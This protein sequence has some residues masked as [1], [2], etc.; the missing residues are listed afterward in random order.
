EAMSRANDAEIDRVE[1]QGPSFSPYFYF[2]DEDKEHAVWFLDAVT[3]LNQLREVRSQKA[4]GLA[5]YRL[6]TED[7]AIWDALS[8]PQ[9]F[10]FDTRTRQSLEMIKSTD[11]IADVGEGEIV[12]VD[13]DRKDGMRKLAVDTDGYLTAKYVQFAQ[14]PTLYHQG[15]GGEHQVAITFD[16]GPDPRWTPKILDILKAANAKATFFLVG[17][18]AERYPGLVRR[19]VNEG[20]EIG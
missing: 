5:L 11:T 1:V 8:A 6:G 10:K 4:G 14:F 9:D 17:V 16:D 13:E 19:I 12:T 20:H 2:Q 3:F 7:P 15:A 18:N